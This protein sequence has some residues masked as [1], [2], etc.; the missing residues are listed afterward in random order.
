MSRGWLR[1][2]CWE[3]T[4]PCAAL[5]EVGDDPC[6]IE[7]LVADQAAELDVMNERGDPDGVEPVAGQQDESDCEIH[8]LVA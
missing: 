4:A 8:K 6:D 5:V 7:S 1:R 3:I 2:A